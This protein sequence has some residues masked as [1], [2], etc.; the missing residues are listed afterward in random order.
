ME[1]YAGRSLDYLMAAHGSKLPLELAGPI[2][3]QTL[4]G[5]AF[6][7]EQGIVHRDLKPQNILRH[8]RE[9]AIAVTGANSAR[10]Q[11]AGGF[12]GN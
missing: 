6:A 10:H 11:Q 2:I 8:A 1:Y 3:L 9:R 4:K 12:A 5:L 7:H